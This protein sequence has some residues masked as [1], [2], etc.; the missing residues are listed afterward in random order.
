[1]LGIVRPGM[2]LR[3]TIEYRLKNGL[4]SDKSP[5]EIVEA[6]LKRRSGPKAGQFYSHL[7]DGRCIAMTAQP[8]V[9]GGTVITAVAVGPG[10]QVYRAI[11]STP[12]RGEQVLGGDYRRGLDLVRELEA[13]GAQLVNNAVVWNVSRD[14]EIGISHDGSA[15]MLSAR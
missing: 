5:D 6:M 4:Q 3:Q 8:M 7:S 12:L 1:M 15:R 11:T 2:T 9:G 14:L 13:T 10:G